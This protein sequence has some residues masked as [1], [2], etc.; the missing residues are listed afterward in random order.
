MGSLTKILPKPLLPVRG[1]P[2]IS[3][4]IRALKKHGCAAP[5]VSLSYKKEFLE[6]YLQFEDV[7]FLDNEDTTM[8]DG[9]FRSALISEDSSHILCLSADVILGEEVF[10][11]VLASDLKPEESKVFVRATEEAKYK[12]WYYHVENE[13]L[14]DLSKEQDPQ[15]FERA[16]LL[17]SVQAVRRMH[18][19]FFDERFLGEGELPKFEGFGSG[20]MLALKLLCE[21]KEEVRFESV[22]WNVHNVNMVEDL[23]A[24]PPWVS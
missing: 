8:I 16:G 11:N 22:D 9:L 18:R 21:N 24:L 23:R 19:T 3:R 20:W 12:S 4:H 5:I 15:A 17:L 6:A 14:V 10:P 7:Q 2:L 13:R 1:I